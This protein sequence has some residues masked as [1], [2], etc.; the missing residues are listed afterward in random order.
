MISETL[1]T[2]SSCCNFIFN[3]PPLIPANGRVFL[4]FTRSLPMRVGRKNAICGF[5]VLY[6]LINR[7]YFQGAVK[8]GRQRIEPPS[9]H[10]LPESME[11]STVLVGQVGLFF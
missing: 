8:T 6:E 10:H 2:V 9:V 1:S 3:S 7:I 4:F 5:I 11:D